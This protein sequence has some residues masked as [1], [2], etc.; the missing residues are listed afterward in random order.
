MPYLRAQGADRFARL[1]CFLGA[2]LARPRSCPAARWV[3][4]PSRCI[5]PP[6]VAPR[7]R[8]PLPHSGMDGRSDPSPERGRQAL[9]RT[10]G[11]TRLPPSP[12]TPHT[13]GEAVAH[14]SGRSAACPGG[15][16]A[17]C[18]ARLSRAPGASRPTPEPL[19]W[20]AL[21][22]MADHGSNRTWGGY[23]YLEFL[24]STSHRRRYPIPN[25]RSAGCCVLPGGAGH[26]AARPMT[27]QQLYPPDGKDSRCYIPALRV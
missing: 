13:P 4:W 11:H 7:S 22:E 23:A 18:G 3:P 25:Q 6:R 5:G 26:R 9:V 24:S 2:G 17:R 8:E 12:L 16:L 1:T 19:P 20:Q 14:A 15:M 21:P 27:S 10:G